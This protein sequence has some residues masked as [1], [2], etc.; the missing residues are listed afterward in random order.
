MRIEVVYSPINPGPGYVQIKH[1]MSI[2]DAFVQ[3]FLDNGGVLDLDELSEMIEIDIFKIID[4]TN[5][6]P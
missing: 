5:G 4:D 1:A 3:E 2:L 6:R